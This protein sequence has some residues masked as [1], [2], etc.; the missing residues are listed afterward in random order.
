[1]PGQVFIAG[2]WPN[3]ARGLLLALSLNA[4]AVAAAPPHPPELD[5]PAITAP[6]GATKAAALDTS[7]YSHGDPTDAEQLMLELINR[8]R[9]NPAGEGIRLAAPPTNI[10]SAYTYFGVDTSRLIADFASYPARP[11]LAF[12]ASLIEAARRHS[13]DMAAR[14][15]QG[16]VGSDGSTLSTRINQSGYSGWTNVAENVFAFA[17]DVFYG[18]A[19]FNVDWGV[20]SLGHRHNLMNFA[21]SDPIY[22]EIGIGIIDVAQ[23]GKSVGPLVITEDFGLRSAKRFVVGVV[24][25]DRDGDGSYS[26]GEGIAGVLVSTSQGNYA[27]TSM[28]GGYAI[29][30]TSANGDATVTAQGAGIGAPQQVAVELTGANLKVDFIAGAGTAAVLSSVIEFYNA[31]LDH[32]FITWGADE[33]AKLDAGTVIKGWTRTGTT[34]KAY[35]TAQAGTSPVCR[36][37]IPP[38]LGDSHFFGRGTTECDATGRNNPS[39]VLEDPAFMQMVL[40]IGG[41]CP[42]STQPVYRVFSNRVDANH[43][44]MTDRA[45]RDQMVA[46]G[47]LA[48]GDGPDLVVM[49]APR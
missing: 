12:N 13:N 17:E 31:S 49:C 23:L 41:V 6:A 7:P 25:D 36:Y 8:A 15:F 11:P 24:F 5:P 38:G 10:Q 28:S 1:M 37:Y 46:K 26:V 43:R 34:F 22:T 47:W 35:T 20:S 39:F 2:L 21:A 18:H 3:L 40:P 4:G 33:I 29:P 30:L 27:Y 45:V 48:E 44:Y 42:A 32:Y 14:G 9:A 16:H 19:G